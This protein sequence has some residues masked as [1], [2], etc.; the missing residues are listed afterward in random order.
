MDEREL[1]RVGELAVLLETRGPW[2]SSIE[3]ISSKEPSLSLKGASA[4]RPHTL[5]SS[6]CPASRPRSRSYFRSSCVSSRNKMPT[7]SPRTTT[8]VQTK[9][10]RRYG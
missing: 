3:L 4:F 5:F 7:A 9:F 6:H 8:A 2:A 10:G 1:H